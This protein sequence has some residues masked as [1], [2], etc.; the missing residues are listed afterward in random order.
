MSK[1][2]GLVECTDMGKMKYSDK[3]S[4]Q[5]HYVNHKTHTDWPEMNSSVSAMTV[6]QWTTWANAQPSL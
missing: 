2:E 4:S 5:C 1:Y 3:N 6:Q